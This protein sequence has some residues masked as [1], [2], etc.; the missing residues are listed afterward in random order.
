MCVCVCALC[1]PTS[2]H[3]SP[4]ARATTGI[5]GMTNVFLTVSASFHPYYTNQCNCAVILYI[6]SF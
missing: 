1:V 4:V 3:F 5:F 2:C 6:C